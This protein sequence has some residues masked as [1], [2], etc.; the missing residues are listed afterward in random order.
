MFTCFLALSEDK[1]RYF[2]GNRKRLG[3]MTK[4]IFPRM[5]HPRLPMGLEAV[6]EE[7]DDAVAGFA[8]AVG[9]V[10][11]GVGGVAVGVVEE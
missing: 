6:V 7:G 5:G 9:V 11:E 3:A 2:F 10:F 8:V 4:G 1:G